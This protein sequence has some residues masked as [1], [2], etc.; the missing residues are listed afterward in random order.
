MSSSA[1]SMLFGF[2]QASLLRQSRFWIL[3]LAGW[4][5]ILP[6]YFR[7]T[8]EWGIRLGLAPFMT[9][10]TAT[11]CVAA[12]AC[13]SIL[14][15][16]YLRMP[17]RWL[18]GV[19]A[20]PIAFALS[21]LGAVP[22]TTIMALLVAGTKSIPLGPGQSYVAWIF[23]NAFALMAM[24][25]GAFLW[26]MHSDQARK[27]RAQF[28]RVETF[29]RE[30]KPLDPQ[31]AVHEP[32]GAQGAT[33][34]PATESVAVPWRPNDQVRLREGKSAKFCRIRDIAYVQAA[35]DYTEVHLCNGELV[36]VRERLRYWELRLPEVFVRIH[37]STLINLE[38]SEELV[39][40]DGAWRV[41]LRG[42]PEPLTV[43]RRLVRALRAKLDGRQCRHSV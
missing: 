31:H 43:S 12:M 16:T 6:L 38:L 14:A 23:F 8:I 21:L 15:G 20:I 2:G 1:F 41:R 26:L 35:D 24:W 29:A 10:A 7:E 9:L 37:R 3:Q 33:P 30:G 28:L 27:S 11:G 5:L 32:V 36:M 17:P 13:S 18:T 22:L 19:R 4:P 34:N 40:L 42:W 39:R 25:N